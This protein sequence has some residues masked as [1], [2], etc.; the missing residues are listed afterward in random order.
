M[1]VGSRGQR[2]YFRVERI[3]HSGA[4]LSIGVRSSSQVPGAPR[5][6]S[7][8]QSDL[9]PHA[10]SDSRRCEVLT[11]QGGSVQHKAAD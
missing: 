5:F 3:Q 11:N 6:R 1:V 4:V 7:P 10:A 8:W 9:R 2:P